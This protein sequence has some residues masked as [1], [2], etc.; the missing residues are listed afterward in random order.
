MDISMPVMDGLAATSAIHTL[1]PDA[2]IVVVTQHDS[3][4]MR[5]RALDCGA[6]HFLPKDNLTALPALLTADQPA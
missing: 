6:A 3:P 5:R 1:H 2:K 4:A